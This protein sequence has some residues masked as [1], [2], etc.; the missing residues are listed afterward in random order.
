M[1]RIDNLKLPV[2]AKEDKLRAACAHALRVS[3]EALVS[4]HLLRRSIDAREGVKLVCS[5]AVEVKNESGV[6]R[7]CKNKKM[8]SPTRR[9]N[10]RR[11]RLFQRRRSPLSLSARGPAGLFLRAAAG[12][13]RRKTYLIRARARGRAAKARCRALLAHGRA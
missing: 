2:G 4:V 13:L 10:I 12:P 9:R 5:C 1:L 7:R 11:P 8:C 6:L 3:E